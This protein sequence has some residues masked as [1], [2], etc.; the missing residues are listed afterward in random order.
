MNTPAH[1]VFSLVLLGRPNAL[2][3]A[4]AILIGALLP[5]LAM[6]V[7]YSAE[8]L[9]GTP[10]NVI[11]SERYF[12][13]HWQNQIDF[14]NSIPLALVAVGL[15]LWRRNIWFVMLFASVIVHCL[16]DLATHHDDAHRHFYPLSHW[17]FESP[18]SYWNPAYHGDVIG[19]IE[20]AAFA[21]GLFWL[22]RYRESSMS[23]NLSRKN[24]LLKF[25]LLVT[26]VIYGLFFWYVVRNWA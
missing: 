14:T 10:E 9:Q 16:L 25:I 26:G 5:D 20:I 13:P 18:F 12:L 8:K 1:V 23:Q 22:W 24:V 17:R 4:L 7:F 6:F 11:W 19:A 15:A 3:Y 2:R 21:I